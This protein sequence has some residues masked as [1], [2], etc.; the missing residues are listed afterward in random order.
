M[1]KMA[2]KGK[3]RKETDEESGELSQ[4]SEDDK[5]L[6]KNKFRRKL[7]GALPK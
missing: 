2:K 5:P 6:R 3:K 7:G 1:G 4:S